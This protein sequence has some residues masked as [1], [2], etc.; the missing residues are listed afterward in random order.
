MANCSNLT[1]T[2]NVTLTTG[3]FPGDFCH[4]TM[5]TTYAQFFDD[6]ITTAAA[7]GATYWTGDDTPLT[8][9]RV[10]LKQDG[11]SAPGSC[12]P[13]L[14]WYFHDGSNWDTPI[15]VPVAALTGASGVTA[16]TYGGVTVAATGIVTAGTSQTHVEETDPT[17]GNNGDFWY[18]YYA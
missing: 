8:T 4:S 11:T 10:W 14:G 13:P 2:T 1:N 18:K 17:G 16:G 5:A 12:S 9:N 3:T 6:D 7:T 15:P